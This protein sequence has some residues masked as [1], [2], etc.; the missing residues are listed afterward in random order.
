MSKSLYCVFHRK[1]WMK[2]SKQ[3]NFSSVQLAT[4]PQRQ[5][6]TLGVGGCRPTSPHQGGPSWT[7][8]NP[9]P[10]G[11]CPRMGV[12][13]EAAQQEVTNRLGAS[14]ESFVAL[15]PIF[16]LQMWV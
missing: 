9:V 11:E 8:H 10:P 15:Y 13:P 16:L 14:G 12:G 6:G 4:P 5:L 3:F 2:R 1:E 7:E